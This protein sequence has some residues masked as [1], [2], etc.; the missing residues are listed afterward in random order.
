MTFPR[1]AR[2]LE[3]VCGGSPGRCAQAGIERP[4]QGLEAQLDL[5]RAWVPPAS[6]GGATQPGL[7]RT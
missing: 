6:N 3:H 7:Q 4:P 5:S 2:R 1:G